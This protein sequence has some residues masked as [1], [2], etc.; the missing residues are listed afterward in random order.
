M[1]IYFLKPSLAGDIISKSMSIIA[2]RRLVYIRLNVLL[3]ILVFIFNNW[4]YS[5]YFFGRTLMLSQF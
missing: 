2:F 4:Q 1:V 5:D 3:F